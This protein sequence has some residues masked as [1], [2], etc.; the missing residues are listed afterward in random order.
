NLPD[1]SADLL[2]L[3]R[4]RYRERGGD[5]MA[6]DVVKHGYRRI[7]CK[8]ALRGLR[9]RVFGLQTP[10]AEA[11]AARGDLIGRRVAT[12]AFVVAMLSPIAT[13]SA[14][15][16]FTTSATVA[17]TSVARGGSGNLTARVTS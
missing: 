9:A 8:E 14:T 12:G 1:G 2:R 4:S 16:T 11:F 10:A 6:R 17:P 5:P 3:G 15:P 13:P 7:G